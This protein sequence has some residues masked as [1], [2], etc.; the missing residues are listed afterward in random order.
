[1]GKEDHSELPGRKV[2]RLFKDF[3]AFSK[4]SS[5]L[6]QTTEIQ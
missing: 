2:K 1:M 5:T 4:K 6:P 3:L